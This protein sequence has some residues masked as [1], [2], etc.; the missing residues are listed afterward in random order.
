V[1]ADRLTATSG[2]AKRTALPLQTLDRV[3]DGEDEPDEE[4]ED[5]AV[6]GRPP[7]GS[8]HVCGRDLTHKEKW[9]ADRRIRT[10]ANGALRLL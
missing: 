8:A 1:P 6:P 10:H 5:D 3:A 9:I 7:L 2:G 4:D